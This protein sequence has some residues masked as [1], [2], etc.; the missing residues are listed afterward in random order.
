MDKRQSRAGLRYLSEVTGRL[1][2][3][4][5]YLAVSRAV[6]AGISV[7]YALL[8][9]TVIDAAVAGD[10]TAFFS[11]IV[12]FVVLAAIQITL[13]AV[14][15]WLRA[16]TNAV[17]DK[18][19]K[20]RLY[21]ALLTRDYASVA[22]VHSG[23]WMNRL[24][25]DA[26]TV[27]GTV[28]SLI[29]NVVGM[30]VRLVGSLLVIAMLEPRFL[31]VILPA[32]ALVV[33][34]SAGFRNILRSMYLAIRESE[35]RLRV[36][37]QESLTNLL[38]VRCYSAEKE[39]AGRAEER[40]DEAIATRMRRVRFSNFCNTGYTAVMRCV[41]VLVVAFCGYGILLGTMTYGTFTAISTLIGQ[42][43]GPISNLS[44]ILPRYYAM[45]A[46]V[47]RLLEAEGYAE[48]KEPSYDLTEIRR[49][50]GEDFAGLSLE[51]LRFSYLPPVK[52]KRG[53]MPIVL[54][55][56]SLEVAKGD[57]VALVGPSGCGKSTLL[58]LLMSLYPPDDGE[59]RV[60]LNEEATAV[61]GS[62]AEGADRGK[63]AQAAAVQDREIPVQSAAVQEPLDSRWRR[64]FAYVP[65]GNQLMTGTIR[66][67]LAFSDEEAMRRDE[68]LW[69]ALRTACAEEFV[70][71]LEE[72]LD[73]ELGERGAGL[74]EGQMQRLAIARAVFSDRPVLLLDECTSS[75]DAETEEKLLLNL[76]RMTDR[77][78]LIV[79]HRKAALSICD[80][81]VE[82]TADGC[83][84][85]E[86]SS[87][88]KQ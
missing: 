78:V 54:K 6:L 88:E 24:T 5:A 49:R 10:R 8:L 67:I 27:A 66:E 60:L 62:T 79:T 86:T 22:A 69:Q 71:E 33:L 25:G 41:S 20:S 80:K 12:R 4:I 32:A 55:D 68:E 73:A 59:C 72:G 84:V 83:K 23:E 61:S 36:F 16:K 81:I 70:V 40:M 77:T 63:P 76:R 46:S 29:P 38:V 31:Y 19:I 85:S 34:V 18:R 56:V 17:L 87:P 50:Y 21:H 74:S 44:G 39:M 53:N 15:R 64:L 1:K 45:M 26:G 43:E 82:F 37:L 13:Q 48:E 65:Q 14:N 57:Y 47:D 7:Y 9:R 3:N 52:G 11:G 35:G 51:H 42:A 30:L 58:K 2:G 75:L 28:V